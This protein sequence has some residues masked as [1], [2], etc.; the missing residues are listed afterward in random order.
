MTSYQAAARSFSFASSTFRRDRMKVMMASRANG[1]T[2]YMIFSI[3]MQDSGWT[4]SALIKMACSQQPA[5]DGGAKAA[6]QLHAQRSAGVHR[7]VHTLVLRQP[8]VLGAGC[9]HGVHVA[10]PRTLTQ[11]SDCGKEQ[12]QGHIAAAHITCHSD[13]CTRNRLPE[14]SS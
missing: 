1:I 13:Q 12:H 6:A 8:S 11:S 10:L 3:E 4:A 7:S 14:Y 9:D 2:R 5:G